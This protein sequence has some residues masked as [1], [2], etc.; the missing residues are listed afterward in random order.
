MR[1][2]G[3][4]GRREEEGKEGKKEGKDGEKEEERR[5]EGRLSF[6]S[7]FRR[8][9]A[10]CMATRGVDPK[11]VLWRLFLSIWQTAIREEGNSVRS[12]NK[13]H[14][15]GTCFFHPFPNKVS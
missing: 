13:V 12:N 6:S 9:S 7:D 8:C 14:T 1:K 3:R 4:K 2:G 5:E 11:P 15:A 10:W